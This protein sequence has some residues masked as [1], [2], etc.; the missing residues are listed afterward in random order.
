VFWRVFE[1]KYYEYILFRRVPELQPEGGCMRFSPRP[2][3]ARPHASYDRRS[4]D[5][6]ITDQFNLVNSFV[7][8]WPNFSGHLHY[9][10]N[11]VTG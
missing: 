8:G 1:V 6:T 5:Q 4:F 3:T 7:A 9:P 11:A 2:Y 10:V